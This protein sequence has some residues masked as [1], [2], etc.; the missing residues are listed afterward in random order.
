MDAEASH[1]DISA[2]GAPAASDLSGT[3]HAEG[4][5][6]AG[7]AGVLGTFRVTTIEGSIA[8]T[9]LPATV[10]EGRL[11][12]K[13]LTSTL[14]AKEPGVELSGSVALDLPRNVAT[15]DLQARSSSLRALSRAP[16]LIGGSAS[17]RAKGT[18][19]LATA[20]IEA[21]TTVHGDGVAYDAF[22]AR[23]LD[24]TTRLTG[25]IAAPSMDVTFNATELQLQTKDK[26]PL[27]YPTASGRARLVFVPSL[28]VVSASIQ[29]GEAGEKGAGG[30]SASAANI[31]IVNGVVEARGVT[32]TG[33]GDPLELDVNVGT[34]GGSTRRA[35][36]SISGA[37]R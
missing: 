33:L 4:V 30:I 24:A 35:Q 36:A 22:S 9:K 6:A 15:F 1:V 11:E 31:S 12:E 27:A 20:T 16:N 2:Y 25:P 26:K 5:L 19:D 7:G 13:T 23:R 29:V 14:R 18:Y 34:A 3:V 8:T 28:R 17:A 37:S 32:L 10:I 21:T